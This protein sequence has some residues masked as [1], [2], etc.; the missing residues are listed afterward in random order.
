MAGGNNMEKKYYYG[1]PISDYG[2]EKGYVDYATL[3]NAFN[4]VLNNDIISLTYDI[5]DWNQV[6]GQIDNSEKIEELGKKLDELVEQ[7]EDNSSQI[8][9]N[10]INEIEEEIEELED[11]EH[12]EPEIFQYFIVD[13]LGADLLQRANEILYCN[14]ELDMYVWG[15]AHFGT[16]WDY[17]L[18]SIAID[19]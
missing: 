11:E 4:C 16:C 9:E 12:E 7:N 19:W 6:S 13:E 10:E 15:V 5:G 18:T 17:V 2:L 14:E 1:N 8:L 3:A